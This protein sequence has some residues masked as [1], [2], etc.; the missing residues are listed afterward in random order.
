MKSSFLNIHDMIFVL[1]F[2]ECFFLALLI[3]LIPIQRKQSRYLLMAFILLIAGW[4]M[5]TLLIWN[6]GLQTLRVNST[7]IS[8]VI[9]SICMLL[10]GPCLYL[11]LRSL[12]EPINWYEPR[13]L[14]HILPLLPVLITIF[15]FD[16]DGWTWMPAT[17]MSIQKR[18]AAKFCWAITRC[19]PLLYAIACLHVENQLRKHYRQI[20]STISEFDLKLADLVLFGFLL[21]WSWNSVGYFIGGYISEAANDWMGIADNYLV[22][23]QVNGLFIL[24]LLNSR[25]LINVNLYV[26]PDKTIEKKVS[27]VDEQK[28]K[29]IENAVNLKKIYLENNI[30]LERFS[31]LAGLKSRDVS[32]ILNQYYQ[33]NFFEFI[34]GLRIEEAKRL[35]SSPEYSHLSILDIVYQSGFN[36]QSAFQ[37]FFKRIEGCSPTEYKR[38]ILKKLP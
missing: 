21:H 23:L 2:A 30:N 27:V 12:S 35:L 36:S 13:L 1:A 32:L 26:L 38:A 9:L 34:N 24:G 20:Y 33:L 6:H 3:K 37:R 7:V 18:M 11:Y 29:L 10:Q 25:N 31:E 4:I 19:S 15:W 22:V 28:R 14:I 16:I 8:P 17:E 5:S